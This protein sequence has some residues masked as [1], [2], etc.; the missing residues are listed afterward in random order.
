MLSFCSHRQNHQ[1]DLLGANG[2]RD[3]CLQCWAYLSSPRWMAY[4]V[5]KF[6]KCIPFMHMIITANRV[7]SYLVRS[8][9]FLRFVPSRLSWLQSFV[10]YVETIPIATL[11]GSSLHPPNYWIGHRS[12]SKIAGGFDFSTQPSPQYVSRC[13]WGSVFGC[14]HICSVSL[15]WGRKNMCIIRRVEKYVGG[16][17]G[18]YVGEDSRIGKACTSPSC[19]N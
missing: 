13:R 4:P 16:N 6:E 18:E 5:A 2:F 14:A 1:G 7:Y 12:L 8:S 15:I 3:D 11:P 19:S 9:V 10:S 17:A